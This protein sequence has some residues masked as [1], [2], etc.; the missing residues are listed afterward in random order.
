MAVERSIKSELIGVYVEPEFKKRIEQE[1]I[2][3]DL[4][5]SQLVRKALVFY[6]EN[7][8]PELKSA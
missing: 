5:V 2:L 1:S 8:Q 7:R 6:F 3:L 4:S